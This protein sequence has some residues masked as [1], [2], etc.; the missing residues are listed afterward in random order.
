MSWDAFQREVLAELGHVLYQPASVGHASSA[1][2]PATDIDEALLQRLARAAAM[3]LEQL[4]GYPQ[5]VDAARGLPADAR[6]KRAL[7][8]QLRAL[9][10]CH[11]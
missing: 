3:P 9:R 6:A 7:W 1:Q 11:R 8:P 2:A 5:I 4:L 10:S